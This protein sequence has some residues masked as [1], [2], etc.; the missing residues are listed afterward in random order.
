M[1]ELRARDPLRDPRALRRHQ[2]YNEALPATVKW[3][4]RL[5]PE[6]HPLA[7][8]RRFPR[9]ANVIARSWNDA[10][11]CQH[12]LE[13][14]LVDRRGGRQGFPPEVH[15]ELMTLRDYYQGRY[16][17]LPSPRECADG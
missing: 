10:A 12:A 6:V 15:E 14:L 8:L 5:P 17:H 16:P 3:V 2:P 1:N 11:E 7:L 4:A 13:E 9:I